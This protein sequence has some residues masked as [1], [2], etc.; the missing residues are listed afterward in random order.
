MIKGS[1]LR[2][3][4]E[5]AFDCVSAETEPQA[6]QV[7]DQAAILAPEITTF[8]LWLDLISYMKAWNSSGEHKE[9]MSRASALQFILTRQAELKSA[10]TGG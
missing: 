2:Q 5:L 6:S 8:N 1:D 10:Q 9:P 3:L 4:I 7:Y